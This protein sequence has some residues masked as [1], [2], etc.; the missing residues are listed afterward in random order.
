MEYWNELSQESNNE[1]ISKGNGGISRE[2]PRASN[3]RQR[4]GPKTSNAQQQASLQASIVQERAS[5]RNIMEFDQVLMSIQGVHL[6]PFFH[7]MVTFYEK[8]MQVKGN[9]GLNH[10]A[11]PM[12][13]HVQK[14]F[15]VQATSPTPKLSFSSP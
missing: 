10:H 9:H 2:S 4:A 3:M 15:A 6:V 5:P 1:Q 7:Q 14:L 8:H 13:N 12:P 11:C